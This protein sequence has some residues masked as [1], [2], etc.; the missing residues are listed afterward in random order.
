[1]RMC[2]EIVVNI[3]VHVCMQNKHWFKKK[4]IIIRF[5]NYVTKKLR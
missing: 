4:K 2:V 3:Y 5:I 1:M